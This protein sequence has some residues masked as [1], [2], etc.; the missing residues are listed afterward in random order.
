LRTEEFDS[1]WRILEESSVKESKEGIIIRRISP[2][3]PYDLFLGYEKPANRRLFLIRINKENY[4]EFRQLP[5]MQGFEISP[6]NLNE[7]SQDTII[8]GF[9][10]NN[11]V[12]MDIFS[13]LC[14]DIYKTVI[15]ENNPSIMVKGVI[16]RLLMWHQFLQTF[17]CQGL[18][19][20]YQ[21]GLYGELR[22]LRDVLFPKIG[23]KNA[24]SAWK[25]PI[26]GNQDFLISGT[27]VEVKT[28]IAKQH[29]KI[30]IASEQ[31]LDNGGLNALYI[32]HLSLRE[33]DNNGETLAGIID[34]IR[35]EI[36]LHKGPVHEFEE[37]LFKAGYLDKYRFKYEASGYTDRA[38]SIFLVREN[39]PRIVEKDLKS[40][41]GDVQYSIDL[42]SC[43]PFKVN[44]TD[45]L[46]DLS[47]DK[48]VRRE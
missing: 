8:V 40:G 37:Q 15:S 23:I 41:V 46:S 42:S 24:L 2:D 21:R 9:I 17:G 31:Q 16:N 7:E 13:T 28:S 43:V 11:P 4:T 45:F 25:G 30:L 35:N 47:G 3:D 48:N 5:S 38:I 26:K 29:Q 14:E 20:E 22:F 33:V 39:F 27:A 1:I 12:F 36:D 44:E 19:L 34:Q 6:V 10:L 32:Y 18:S